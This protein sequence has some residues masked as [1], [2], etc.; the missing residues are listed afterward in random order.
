MVLKTIE[1]LFITFSWLLVLP[2]GK[3]V[4]Y[5]NKRTV[6][7][8]CNLGGSLRYRSQV[9]FPRIDNSQREI[10]NSSLND[11]HATKK[12]QIDLKIT[13]LYID[14]SGPPTLVCY[15]MKIHPQKKRTT[16]WK[17]R[18][19]PLQHRLAT[20]CYAQVVFKLHN[21]TCYLLLCCRSFCSYWICLPI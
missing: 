20:T 14:K 1:T 5:Q 16:K 15:K 10:S 11:H 3:G 4:V 21:P 17:A 2:K 13:N 12:T 19:E 6:F 8:F 7:R 9:A 18:E